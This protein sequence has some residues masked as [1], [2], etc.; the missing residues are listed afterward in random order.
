MDKVDNFRNSGILCDLDAVLPNLR[1]CRA[2]ARLL[3]RIPGDTS[4]CLR[5]SGILGNTS[6]NTSNVS[7][8]GLCM[9]IVSPS[10]L[11]S[12]VSARRMY[13]PKQYHYVQE[14]QKFNVADYR[15]RYFLPLPPSPCNMTYPLRYLIGLLLYNLFPVLHALLPW[16]L[17]LI[18][19]WSNSKKQFAKSV[20]YKECENNA[21]TPSLKAT[22]VK[23]VSFAHTTLLNIVASTAK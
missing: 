4:P 18:S 15:P 12:N 17:D 14:I 20:K 9:E 2:I 21:A 22:K 3:P 8:P 13:Y 23:C 16:L 19:G 7:H 5:K 10:S 6:R 1:L 11:P